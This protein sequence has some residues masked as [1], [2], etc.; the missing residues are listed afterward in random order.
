[1]RRGDCGHHGAHQGPGG[2]GGGGGG[3]RRCGI[4]LGG[5]QL[6]AQVLDL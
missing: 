6:G 1:M 5:S 4:R 2:R 3:G